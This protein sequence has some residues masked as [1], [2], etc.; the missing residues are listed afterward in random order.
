MKTL[1]KP[2]LK[3][4]CLLITHPEI[5]KQW[6]PTKNGNLLPS[7]VTYGS[8]KKVFW[9]CFKNEEHC[10]A[11]SVRDAVRYGLSCLHCNNLSVTHPELMEEWHPTKNGK[12]HP[13][14]VTP[15][16]HK[17][18][19][20]RCKSKKKHEWQA[21]I[22]NRANG[23]RCPYCSN[24]KVCEDNCLLTINPEIAKEW[25][26]TKNGKLTP[27]DV[28]P[29]SHKVVWWRCKLK[30]E[31]EWETSVNARAGCPYCSGQKVCEDNCLL[32]LDPELSKEWHPTK[33]GKL[34]PSDVTCGSKKIVWW[35]CKLKKEHEW[36]ASVGDRK[37]KKSGCPYCCNRKVCEDNCLSTVNPELA[38]E[39]HPTKNG[40]LHPSDVTP[41]STKI[42]WWRCKLKKEHEWDASVHNRAGG[43]GC[44][45]CSGKRV[46]EDNCL[47]TINPEIAK[48]WHP[49]KNGKLQPSDVTYGSEKRVWW[50][51][52]LK[53]E[54]EWC[55]VVHSRTGGKGCPYCKKSIGEERIAEI[56]R[57][58]GL[59]FKR[60]V[61][62]KSCRSK[63]CLPFDFLV[64]IEDEKGFLIEF[65]GKHH[66]LPIKR[67]SCWLDEGAKKHFLGVK[68]RDNIKTGWAKNKGVV[69]LIIPYWDFK[70][71][72]RILKDFLEGR[73]PAFSKP[74]PEVR[75]HKKLRA[76]IRKELGIVE[77]EILCGV[78]GPKK[79]IT[80][81]YIVHGS[82]QQKKN[83]RAS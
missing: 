37:G 62:F 63:R 55:A 5:A 21:S 27:Q 68:K 3:K 66:Y 74:P 57:S 12:L 8:E 14:D 50:R 39:W 80:G 24:K 26:P 65:Q 61:N 38:K 42:V 34:Q 83:S 69:L 17:K 73:E 18:I 53:K 7:H 22:K 31:H 82:K 72:D 33:N 4:D 70:N 59:N 35:R 28:L 71:I 23:N 75:K 47:L 76:K 6:H 43:N 10:W 44:P 67:S 77:E 16:S 11:Y 25:H 19:W 64:K 56:L 45:Y 79:C 48:E 9:R 20:W 81:R 30:K 46:C 36:E 49:T 40:N 52:K 2:N 78:V 32:T 29:S 54:H 1:L 60:Q 41:F 58:L 13:S 15:G 51:C